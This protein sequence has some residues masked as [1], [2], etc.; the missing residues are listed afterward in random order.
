M[1]SSSFDIFSVAD[2]GHPVD[3]R[4]PGQQVPGKWGFGRGA[5]PELTLPRLPEP[6]PCQAS[7]AGECQKLRS[8]SSRVCPWDPGEWQSRAWVDWS[9]HTNM[10]SQHI[11]YPASVHPDAASPLSPVVPSAH[12][13]PPYPLWSP[14]PTILCSPGPHCQESDL[15]LG[16]RPKRSARSGLV[17]LIDFL[18]TELFSSSAGAVIS[19]QI[20]V[21]LRCKSLLS[22]GRG[23]LKGHHF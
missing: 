2:P 3:P 5:Q 8:W 22:G 16:N 20:W 7:A 21:H 18:L 19:L 4:E 17:P 14:L 6:G 1:G 15:K 12:Q 9:T 13:P 10:P 11:G 23:N